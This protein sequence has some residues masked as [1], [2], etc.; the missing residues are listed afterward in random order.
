MG[1]IKSTLDLVLEK[2]RHLK[3]NEEEKD[4]VRKETTIKTLRGILQRYQD[5]LIPLQR[6]QEEMQRLTSGLDPVDTPTIFEEI[7]DRIRPESD[8]TIWLA[9]LQTVSTSGSQTL[10]QV[11]ADYSET[12][13]SKAQARKKQL[14][15]AL[16]SDHGVSGSAVMPN[17]QADA[18]WKNLRR[19]L[20]TQFER[21]FKQAKTAFLDSLPGTT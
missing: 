16:E 9:Y 20:R 15:E 21:R 10:R 19:D 4:R 3:L 6:F 11:L 13:N 18:V 14:L 5:G 8:N 2:T 1:E 12:M 17:L 7:L